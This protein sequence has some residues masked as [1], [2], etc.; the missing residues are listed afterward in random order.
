MKISEMVLEAQL[1]GL[2]VF[3]GPAC[4]CC[5]GTLRRAYY[6]GQCVACGN[7]R[8]LARRRLIAAGEAERCK[9]WREKDASLGHEEWLERRSD[10]HAVIAMGDIAR[11]CGTTLIDVVRAWGDRGALTRIYNQSAEKYRIICRGMRED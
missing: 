11:E 6:S 1:K 9:K 4:V 2:K 7:R 8:A 3:H 10:K 5:G